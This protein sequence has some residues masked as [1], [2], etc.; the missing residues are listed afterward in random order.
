MHPTLQFQQNAT[1]CT[2]AGEEIG[3]I[4]H[5]VLHPET[6]VVTHIVVRKKALFTRDE[7]VLPIEEVAQAEEDQITLRHSA[8]ELENWPRFEEK[9]AVAPDD[10]V[11]PSGPHQ[12]LIVPGLP[13]A[14]LPV[15]SPPANELYVEKIEKNIPEG[16]VAIKEGAKVLTSEGEYV[17]K[18]ERLVANAPTDQATHLIISKGLL[19]EEKKLI[20]INWVQQ[21]G[22]DEIHLSVKKV[23]V[24]EL[25]SARGGEVGE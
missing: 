4:T 10:E 11:I 6:K 1:V 8:V 25:G 24:E 14:P 12:P 18:V 13:G 7:R 21:M 17:G 20:P 5:V 3:H 22:E 16:T 2:P 9:H 23:T 19:T 15:N